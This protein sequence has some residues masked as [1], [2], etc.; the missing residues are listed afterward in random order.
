M[1][2]AGGDAGRDSDADID[3]GSVDAGAVD[4]ASHTADA[5]PPDAAAPD[6]SADIPCGEPVRVELTYATPVENFRFQRLEGMS[7]HI[8]RIVVSPGDSSV[9]LTTP[10]G[11][12]WTQDDTT[13]YSLR[14]LSISRRCGDFGPGAQ[15]YANGFQ[16]G[17]ISVLTAD[18]PRAASARINELVVSPG[19]WYINLRNDE[20]PE[21]TNCSFS[22]IW[23][24]FG[25]S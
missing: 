19:V 1:D 5:G 14:T 15:I 13:T 9:D 2:R 16:S 8:T 22:G 18:D 10:P 20:C 21:A 25:P 17:A 24:N 3:A 6:A 12:S 23:R 11:F 4:A 7:T